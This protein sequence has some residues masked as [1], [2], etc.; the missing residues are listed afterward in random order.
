MSEENKIENQTTETSAKVNTEEEISL[1]DLIAVLWKYRW[2]IIGITAAGMFLGVLISI[3]SLKMSPEKSFLPNVYKSSAHMVI[4][5]S[6]SGSSSAAALLASSGLGS[7]AGMAGVSAGASNVNL[8]VY[9]TKCN[10]LLDATVQ[11]FHILER[12]EFKKSKTP[13]HDSRKKMSKTIKADYDKE[14][15]IFTVSC[16]DKDPKFACDLVNFTVE[17]LSEKFDELGVDQN[18]IKKVNLEKNL[19]LSFQEI[20]RLTNQLNNVATSAASGNYVSSIALATTK[21][22]MELTAQQEVYKQLKTQYELLRV[23]MQSETPVFQVLE[24]AEVADMKSGPSRGKLCIIMTFA[25]AFLS[26]FLAFLLNALK[27][28]K[29]DPEAMK[30][31]KG[32]K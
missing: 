32:E 4:Q 21:I 19:D 18:K 23:Q 1:L 2:M 6:K 16:K 17:W 15:G 30:K 8:A 25:F 27:N 31:L 26:V 9:L 7:L 13:R 29:N 22:Q 10:E 14:A 20:T 28:I 3:I 24:R 12:K 11:E 5:D